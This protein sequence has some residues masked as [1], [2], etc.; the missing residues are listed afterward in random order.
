MLPNAQDDVNFLI[1]TFVSTHVK[2]ASV[3][4]AQ[5]GAEVIN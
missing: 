4:S 1:L 2:A 5:G 3:E